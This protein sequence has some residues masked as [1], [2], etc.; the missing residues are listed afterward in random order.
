MTSE[1]VG[2]VSWKDPSDVEISTTTSA[3]A[4]DPGTYTFTVILESGCEI[5]ETILVD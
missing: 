1:A 4:S 5:S 2:S 3:I